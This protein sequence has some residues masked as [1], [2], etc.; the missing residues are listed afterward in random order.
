ML[1]PGSPEDAIAVA[2]PVAA[3][4]AVDAASARHKGPDPGGPR[5][6]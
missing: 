3:A 5:K 6:A 1:D 4:P 2:A